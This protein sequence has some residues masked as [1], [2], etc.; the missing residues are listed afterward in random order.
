[1]VL[2]TMKNAARCETWRDTQNLRD[3]EFLNAACARGAIRRH[4]C[5]GVLITLPG[6][7]CLS[8]GRLRRQAA[9]GRAVSGRV[10]PACRRVCAAWPQ[11]QSL[12]VC[13]EYVCVIEPCDWAFASHLMCVPSPTTTCKPLCKR[14]RVGA[15]T[16][17][18]KG[19]SL[20]LLSV[21]SCLR[22]T[23]TVTSR[24]ETTTLAC[25]QTINLRSDKTT[26]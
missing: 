9:T 18:G 14:P 5:L 6:N 12:S 21:R 10:L 3:V 2:V 24:P 8:T 22:M 1:L 4:V 23:V 25:D 13:C 16:F 26:R 19:P 11:R 17:A 7:W 20:S 15:S